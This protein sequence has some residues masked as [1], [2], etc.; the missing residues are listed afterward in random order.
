MNLNEAEI[1]LLAWGQWNRGHQEL[2]I[3]SIS[4]IGR[5]MVEG[6][7]ASHSTVR[8]EAHMPRRVELVERCMLEQPKRLVRVMKH[9]FIGLEP[10]PIACPKLRM[11]ADVYETMVNQG[12]LAVAEF[13]EIS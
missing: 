6:A 10:A 3:A 8:G 9:Y 5:C 1:M 2:G 7:G 12:I 11:S 4:P 13:V